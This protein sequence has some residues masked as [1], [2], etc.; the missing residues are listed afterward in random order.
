MSLFLVSV[1]PSARRLD[2]LDEILVT[3]EDQKAALALGNQE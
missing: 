2:E 3:A 1:D